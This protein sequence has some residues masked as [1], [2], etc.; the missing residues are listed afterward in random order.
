MISEGFIP[1]LLENSFR[2]LFGI[3]YFVASIV[4]LIIGIVLVVK[5]KMPTFFTKR[6]VGLLIIFLGLLL[7]THIHIFEKL[8]IDV[9]ETSI[10][11]QSW[12]H[13]ASYVTGTGVA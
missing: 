2:F 4:L 11:K 8:L 9:N 6:K 13:F 3:W 10:L 7:F 12:Y 5:R 1:R